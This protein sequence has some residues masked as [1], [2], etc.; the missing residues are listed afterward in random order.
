MDTHQITL[1]YITKNSSDKN[2]KLFDKEILMIK[3]FDLNEPSVIIAIQELT[4]I[5]N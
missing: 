3:T 4:I 1:L 5:N 2:I